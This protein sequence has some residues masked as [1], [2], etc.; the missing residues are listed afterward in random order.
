MQPLHNTRE[1]FH[2]PGHLCT[3][4][5]IEKAET[6]TVFT[7]FPLNESCLYVPDLRVELTT[8]LRA[9]LYLGDNY[10]FKKFVID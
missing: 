10:I 1:T 2:Y 8:T 3:D 5:N 4:T 9:N 6:E 7:I